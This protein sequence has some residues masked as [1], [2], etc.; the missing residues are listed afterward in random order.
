MKHMSVYFKR[1]FFVLFSK[2]ANSVI[3]TQYSLSFAK[4][5]IGPT[6]LTYCC[7]LVIGRKF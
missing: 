4:F 5:T 2:I 7:I 1:R 6:F 3:A